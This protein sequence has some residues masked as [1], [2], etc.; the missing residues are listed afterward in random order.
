MKNTILENETL[1]FILDYL[2]KNKINTIEKAIENNIA[3]SFTELRGYIV[4]IPIE[5]DY[6]ENILKDL[7]EL[8]EYNE[9]PIQMSDGKELRSYLITRPSLNE[10]VNIKFCAQKEQLNHLFSLM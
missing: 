4:T 9:K 5:S 8:K 2:R 1:I 7:R 10:G 3:L 6:P